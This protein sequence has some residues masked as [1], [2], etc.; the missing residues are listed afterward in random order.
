MINSTNNTNKKE[1]IKMVTKF[2]SKSISKVSPNRKGAFNIPRVLEKYF[3]P[4]SKE[5]FVYSIL[6]F[7]AGSFVFAEPLLKE[8]NPVSSPDNQSKNTL[9][10]DFTNGN[11]QP[12]SEMLRAIEEISFYSPFKRLYSFP[13]LIKAALIID[14]RGLTLEH[15]EAVFRYLFENTKQPTL[16]CLQSETKRNYALDNF[17][18]ITED[19]STLQK[20]RLVR[21][22]EGVKNYE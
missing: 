17:Y 15:L 1:K 5:L 13:I 10:T 22:S 12:Q 9:Q 11:N 19:S 4:E 20:V 3:V 18:L 6:Y 8:V 21:P 2:P 14:D 7:R 16:I